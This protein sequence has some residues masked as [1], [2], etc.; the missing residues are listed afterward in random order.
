[1]TLFQVI[2]EEC[3]T[4]A[5]IHISASKCWDMVREK[6]NL[7]IRKHHTLGRS[8]S[9]PL[10]PPGS[11]D[12]LEMFG[13]TSPAIIQVKSEA[14]MFCRCNCNLEALPFSL[15]CTAFLT[16]IYLDIYTITTLL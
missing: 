5:F 3:P 13:F 2:V 8:Q 10:Q 11:L 14:V 16:I 12:G 7:E 1:M 15:T 6:I 9:P 4:E